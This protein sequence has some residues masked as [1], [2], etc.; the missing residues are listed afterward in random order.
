MAAATVRRSVECGIRCVRFAGLG[1]TVPVHRLAPQVQVTSRNVATRPPIKRYRDIMVGCLGQRA[2]LTP[3]RGYYVSNRTWPRR[4]MSAER[5]RDCRGLRRSGGCCDGRSVNP[6]NASP[7]RW[8]STD[9]LNR[10]PQAERRQRRWDNQ[11][12]RVHVRMVQ[13]LALHRVDTSHGGARQ[14]DRRGR[15]RAPRLGRGLTRSRDPRMRTRLRK[16]GG[17]V[18]EDQ[19]P[20]H[21]SAEEAVTMLTL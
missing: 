3:C 13:P 17:T 5:R 10:Q 19:V 6:R 11:A 14:L 15:T 20:S 8:G 4:S 18:T 2:A 21:L 9:D 16:L 1:G 7:R 12:S